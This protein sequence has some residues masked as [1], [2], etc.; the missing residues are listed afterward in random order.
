[1]NTVQTSLE[2]SLLLSNCTEADQPKCHLFTK[3]NLHY[4][5]GFLAYFHQEYFA[6]Q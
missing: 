2:T 1:M 4:S 5:Y 6:N 3:A